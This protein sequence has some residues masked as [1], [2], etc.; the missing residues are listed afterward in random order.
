[1]PTPGSFWL[2]SK[3]EIDVDVATS[4]G[5]QAAEVSQLLVGRWWLFI[6]QVTYT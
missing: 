1:M 5:V 4:I 6:K 3:A 2:E